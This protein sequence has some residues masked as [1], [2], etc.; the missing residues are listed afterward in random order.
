MIPPTLD[1]AAWIQ[2][3]ASGTLQR[4]VELGTA[5]RTLYLQERTA[6]WFGHGFEPLFP[7]RFTAGTLLA[8]GDCPGFTETLWY[9]RVLTA[10]WRVQNAPYVATPRYLKLP[11]QEGAGL[12]VEG[13]LPAWLGGRIPVAVVAKLG[14][15]GAYLPPVNPC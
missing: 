5:W 13:S 1:E 2:Q 8:E 10:R 6:F 14:P 7:T 9:T 4:A 15:G 3:C 11:D 12:M